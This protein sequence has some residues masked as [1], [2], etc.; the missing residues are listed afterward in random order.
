MFEC[1]SW[2]DG[3]FF[4]GD[5]WNFLKEEVK[6]YLIVQRPLL[7]LAIFSTSAHL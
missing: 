7:N 6:T 5:D 1:I 2:L 4:S 3:S